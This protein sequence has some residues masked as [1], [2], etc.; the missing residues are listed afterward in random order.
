MSC[1]FNIHYV[2]FECRKEL[3]RRLTIHVIINSMRKLFL[4]IK[5]AFLEGIS[6][7]GIEV[8]GIV[9]LSFL[10]FVYSYF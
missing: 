3:K 4:T 8:I 9:L 2:V 6:Y 5:G 10:L 1:S 7:I